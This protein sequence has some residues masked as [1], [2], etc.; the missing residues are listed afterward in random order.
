MTKLTVVKCIPEINR[1][2]TQEILKNF[3]QHNWV[4]LAA[5]KEKKKFAASSPL[6]EGKGI[7]ITSGGSMGRNNI[8]FQSIKNLTNSA[9]AT[10]KWL[11]NKCLNPKDC[12]ILN[13]LPLHHVSGFMPWWRH[14]TWGAKHY[15]ISHSMM[16]APIELKKFSESITYS[17]RRPLITS[18]VPIQLANLIDDQYGLEWLKSLSVIWV[19]GASISTDLANKARKEAINL[20]PCYG[21]TE[22][23][24]MVTCLN[25]SDFLKGSNSVG[26]PLEDVEIEINNRN[27][28]K[29]KTNRIAL[30]KSKDN[31]FESIADSNGWWEA[32]DLAQYVYLNNQKALQIIG[33][34]DSAINSGGETIFPEDI[35]MQLLKIISKNQ[36]PVEDIFVL[37]VNDQKW[38]QRLVV[39][40]KLK[41][42]ESK[43]DKIVSL[44]NHLIKDWPPS[45]K[46][47]NWYDCPELSRNANNKWELNKWQ[48]WVKLNTP[49]H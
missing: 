7:V 24:A 8:C 35:E 9:H 27:S 23:A 42:Q 26:F 43:S 28:L 17:D 13:P 29:I 30:S 11:K 18:L 12:I 33:R 14:Q 15:W 6:P 25:P 40:I 46:P 31:K 22:T 19:G 41:K 32:G 39:L 10:G 45:K 44:F 20:A 1:L 21:S 38:G 48:K 3:E 47:L 16:H 36:I 34:K 37:G 2:S 4:Y 49:I 5:P